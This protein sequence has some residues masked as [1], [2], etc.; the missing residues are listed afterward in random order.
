MQIILERRNFVYT[1][2]NTVE[3][4]GSVLPVDKGKPRTRVAREAE[5]LDCRKIRILDTSC[6]D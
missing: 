6:R 1:R 2:E 5:R 3:V 4:A